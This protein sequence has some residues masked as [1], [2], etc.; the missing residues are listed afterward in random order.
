MPPPL[1]CPVC[2]EPQETPRTFA[3]HLRSE[4]PTTCTTCLKK[5]AKRASLLRHQRKNI[6]CA[7]EKIR[8]QQQTSDDA[9]HQCVQCPSSFTRPHDLR[10]H[11]RQLHALDK[12]QRLV[13]P[14]RCSPSTYKH[15][16]SLRKHMKLKH[17]TEPPLTSAQLT[18]TAH[19]KKKQGRGYPCDRCDKVFIYQGALRKH[20][21]L[22]HVL[23][24]CETC[25][26][27]FT[28]N[29]LLARHIRLN[30]RKRKKNDD[31]DDDDDEKKKKKKQKRNARRRVDYLS[32]EGD[33]PEP[34]RENDERDIAE[35]IARN[36]GAVKNHSR[37][38]KKQTF[39]NV[40]WRGDNTPDF[41]AALKPLS[42]HRHQVQDP[43]VPRLCP[44]KK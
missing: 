24:T 9:R 1:K 26:A 30:H 23:F 35:V 20:K 17:P 38:G 41:N 10:R 3:R 8:Q 5:Y 33:E 37:V 6:K 34:D 39:I 7:R 43:G 27:K 32:D 12:I 14:L 31:D 15:A 13:C 29:K 2:Q 21:F 16:D 11:V 19:P 22:E 44:E 36:W 25:Q 28:N 42:K 18:T 4:H 40:R